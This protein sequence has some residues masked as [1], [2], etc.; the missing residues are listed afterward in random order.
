MCVLCLGSFLSSN[1]MPDAALRYHVSKLWNSTNTFGLSRAKVLEMTVNSSPKGAFGSTLGV[2][3]ACSGVLEPHIRGLGV[4]LGSLGVVFHDE[5]GFC[6]FD[7]I[8][9]RNS[10]FCLSGQSSWSHLG[11]QVTPE[12]PKLEIWRG[13]DSQGSLVGSVLLSELWNSCANHLQ[14]DGNQRSQSSEPI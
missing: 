8:L 1:W 13:L 6:D 11:A 4:T 10:Y 12:R 14:T 7:A 9:Q 2:W 5:V 3:R